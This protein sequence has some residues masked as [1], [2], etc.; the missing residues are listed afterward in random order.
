MYLSEPWEPICSMC[1]SFPF[2]FCVH[3]YLELD[4]LLTTVRV[5]LEKQRTLT[6]PMHLVY[7]SCFFVESELLLYFCCFVC[8]ILFQVFVVGGCFPCLVFVLR[9]PLESWFPWLHFVILPVT[10][11]VLAHLRVMQI[12]ILLLIFIICLYCKYVCYVSGLIICI[13]EVVLK[14]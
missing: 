3:L 14:L 7:A 8:I 12:W 1:I 5:F 10:F 9:F 11:K 4:F 6:L 2:L 13:R